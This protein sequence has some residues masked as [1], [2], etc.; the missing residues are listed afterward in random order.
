[1]GDS[2]NLVLIIN[3]YILLMHTKIPKKNKI[4]HIYN[5]GNH[6]EVIGYTK[7]DYDYLYYMVTSSFDVRSY[8]LICFC[9]M[10]NHFHLLASQTGDYPI[11]KA[12]HRLGFGYT[13]YFNK[14]YGKTGHLF[15]GVYKRKMIVSV[16]ELIRVTN[17]I[18][19]NPIKSKKSITM[20]QNCQT[21]FN[22]TLYNYYKMIFTLKGE[23]DL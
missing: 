21:Y 10:P 15:Q 1:M 9:I 4:Y 20:G 5:R 13:K 17:Y 23:D 8:N 11:S 22:S 2:F 12:M 3:W 18:L 16:G 14:K 6:R 7:K 19:S